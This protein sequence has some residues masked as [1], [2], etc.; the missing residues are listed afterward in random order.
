MISNYKF[1]FF[2]ASLVL[3]II[4]LLSGMDKLAT[5]DLSLN[6]FQTFPDVG[7]G[8]YQIIITLFKVL[9]KEKNI[10]HKMIYLTHMRYI[11]G[12]FCFICLH[13]L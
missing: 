6:K 4:V 10:I 8:K 5:L 11:G 3:I 7:I 1:E 9:R 12:I 13:Q 2:F